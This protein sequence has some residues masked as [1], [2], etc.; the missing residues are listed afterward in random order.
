MCIVYNNRPLIINN[1]QVLLF[2]AFGFR[3]SDLELPVNLW[4]G[5]DELVSIGMAPLP[6][7]DGSLL[8]VGRCTLNSNRILPLNR[9]L[10]A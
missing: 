4:E 1:D 5:C 9:Q 3:N 6:G 8:L 2:G 7:T 10:H